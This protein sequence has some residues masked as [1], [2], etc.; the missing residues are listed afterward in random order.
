MLARNEMEWTDKGSYN[1]V[2]LTVEVEPDHLQ[3]H[4]QPRLC[5]GNNSRQS[6]DLNSIDESSGKSGKK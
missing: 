4:G 1:D 2:T 5:A 3:M 6:L